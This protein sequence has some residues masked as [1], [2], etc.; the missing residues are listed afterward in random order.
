MTQLKR[1]IAAVF[2]AVDKDIQIDQVVAL[3]TILEHIALVIMRHNVRKMT[4][5]L[6][7]A[8]TVALADHNGIGDKTNRE[9]TV[10]VL[11]CQLGEPVV[12]LGRERIIAHNLRPIRHGG[13]EATE[14]LLKSVRINLCL[15]LGIVKA[16]RIPILFLN[17]I[18][19]DTQKALGCM[20][21]LDAICQIGFARSR[22]SGK[23]NQRL[24]HAG[25]PFLLPDYLP[26]SWSLEMASISVTLSM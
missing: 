13:I 5:R 18:K 2:D 6:K 1:I 10:A 15:F 26:R 17:V 9:H 16:V 3:A 19:R 14:P 11:V 4:R 21:S 23:Q 24:F 20:A 22:R 7:I 12:L 25:K 8:S